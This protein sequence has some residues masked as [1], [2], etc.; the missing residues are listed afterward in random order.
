[1]GYPIKD[2]KA[3][4][5]K[6]WF[7]RTGEYYNSKYLGREPTQE[8]KEAYF[9]IK[10]KF[11]G[12][13]HRKSQWMGRYEDFNDDRNVRRVFEEDWFH[14]DRVANNTRFHNEMVDYLSKNLNKPLSEVKK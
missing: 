7:E 1:M 10:N 5:L 11:L 14:F 4:K 8:S 13:T 3:Q 12:W 2:A 9:K 6:E